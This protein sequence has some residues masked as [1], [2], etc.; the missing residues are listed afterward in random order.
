MPAAKRKLQF[1]PAI[2][3]EEIDRYLKLYD[4]RATLLTRRAQKRAVQ[5]HDDPV[6]WAAEHFTWPKDQFLSPYQ[7]E[8]LNALV[9]HRRVAV[10][11]PH[12]L[13][14]TAMAAITI[15][16]FAITRDA[17]E[18]DWKIPVTA[19][20]WR[21]LQLYLWPEVHKWARRLRWDQI[22]RPPFSRGTELLHLSLKLNFGE[23]FA[24]ASDDP[25]AIEGAHAT[26][27][28]YVFDEAKA[29]PAETF[30]A[31]EGAFSTAG[32]TDGT[33]AY[34]LAISTPGDPSG[35]FYDI[36]ARI[37]GT[38]RWWTRHVTL[39]EA[40]AAGRV[41]EEWAEDHR[42]LWGESSVY[43]NRV[44]GE[45]ASS[46][47]D[48]VIPLAWVEMANERWRKL[49]ETDGRP[50][51]QARESWQGT[52]RVVKRG[53]KLHTVGVD[54][55]RGGEDK[56]VLALRQ[57]NT[58][59]ELRRFGYSDDT[60]ELAGAVVGIQNGHDG[61]RAIV[62]VIGVGAGVY[63]RVRE[64]GLPCS[65]FNAST[66]VKRTDVTGEFGFT[67]LRSWA[68]WNL[69]EMLDPASM[70]D[71][72]LP[73][74]DRLTGDLV[75]PKWK[76][77][78]GGRIQVE[79]KDDIKKRIHRSTDDGDSVVQAM[80]ESG[81]SW[82]DIYRDAE[83][84]PDDTTPKPHSRKAM[85]RGWGDVY[86]SDEQRAKERA[87]REAAGEE[88]LDQE[89]LVTVPEKPKGTWFS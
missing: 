7:Q 47:E 52:R 77:M 19:S 55:A 43:A 76:V 39:G 69:R 6:G 15:L 65:G 11:G 37:P 38:E 17:E 49:Y 45:F 9:E 24:L 68:W 58:I 20:V 54:V 57:G 2:P 85:S 86:K 89:E 35:R 1:D 8:I 73:P 40:I 78:S 25:T 83:E 46:S 18:V 67:N 42:L 80:S 72:A 59:C 12:G 79:S 66:G 4:E 62:D 26:E 51:G 14:K 61:P 34:A 41:T 75:A 63:D 82:A 36:H 23:A 84:D 71:V 27:L 53:D 5:F 32:T 50:H 64:Q 21:Q 30:D 3:P 48:S 44:L 16:W 31:A 22:G 29:I 74:D 28:L 88:E 70:C 33:N 81:G 10:R 87:E 60:M 56:S 13:G